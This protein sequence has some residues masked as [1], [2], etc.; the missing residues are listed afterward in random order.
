MIPLDTLNRLTKKIA[1]RDFS[2]TTNFNTNDE[3]QNLGDSFNLMSKELSRQFNLMT[4]MSNLDRAI[5]TKMN[6]ESVV[7]AIFNNLE[8]YIEYSYASMI[9]LEH[10]DSD[11]VIYIYGRKH[12]NIK[13]KSKILVNN[14]D[15]QTLFND[16][17]SLMSTVKRENTESIQWLKGVY[18]NYITSFAIRKN[19]KLIALIIIGHQILSKTRR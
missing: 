9:L 18:S 15:I 14:C 3:F 12:Q 17:D 5:L 8:E 4:A 10:N 1:K 11:G 16:S 7:K 13:S 2:D 19:S 6:K